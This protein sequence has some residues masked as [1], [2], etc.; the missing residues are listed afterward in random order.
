MI[1]D[2]RAVKFANE[3]I[4]PLADKV[5]SMWMALQAVGAEFQAK[6]IADVVP[7]KPDEIVADGSDVDGRTPISGHD[8]HQMIALIADLVT[9]GNGDNSKIP[10]VLKCAV[11]IN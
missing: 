10:T 9:M 11:N 8:I 7:D 6:G 2:P 3:R 4:R 5:A 1:E